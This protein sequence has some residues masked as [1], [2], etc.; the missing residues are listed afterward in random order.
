MRASLYLFAT[1][2]ET[3]NDA[4]VVS[5]QLMLRILGGIRCNC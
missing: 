2:K 3:P 4:Q 1:L 5:H